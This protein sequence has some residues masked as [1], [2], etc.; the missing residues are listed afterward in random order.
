MFQ[1]SV[2][3]DEISQD[4]QI[5]IALA[6]RFGLDAVE[7]R[8]VYNKGPFELSVEEWRSINRQIKAAGLRVSAISAPFYKCDMNNAQ[9]IAEHCAGLERCI[10]AAEMLGTDKIRGFAFWKNGV[11]SECLNQIVALYQKP[12]A[13][14]RASGMTLVMESDPSVNTANAAQLAEVLDA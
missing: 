4:L 11:L 9:E 6:E 3:T 5:A 1:T 12:I 2:I 14:L 7:L 8:S 10:A 13:R